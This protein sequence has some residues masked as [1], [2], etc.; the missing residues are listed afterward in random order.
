M[1]QMVMG[2]FRDSKAA[3]EAVSDFVEQGYMED[4]TVV[5]RNEKT[6][7]VTEHEVQKDTSEGTAVGAATG[8]LAGGLAGILAGVTSFVVPG[9]GLLIIG[10]LATTLAA[11][12]AG[13]LTGGLVG[14]LVDWG[15]PQ[16]VAES[17]EVRLKAGEVLVAVSTTRISQTEAL[18]VMN[19]HGAIETQSLTE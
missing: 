5:S 18:G 12:G 8:A 19:A 2:L 6:G 11:V 17:Y 7:E 15:L 16:E 13:A 1:P 10:P 4:V 3:G 14:A 9:V